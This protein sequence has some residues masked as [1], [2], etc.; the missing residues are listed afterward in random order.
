VLS[1]YLPGEESLNETAVELS[2][3][4]PAPGDFSLTASAD[5]M[6]GDSFRIEREP[7]GASNDP[8]LTSEGDKSDEPRAAALARIAGFAGIGDR[9][10]V[11]L[12]VSGT[13]G[14]NNVAAGART[15]IYGADAKAKL[16]T[17][18][19]AYLLVQA[20]YL[21][22]ELDSAGWDSTSAAY[23]TEEIKSNGGYI[24][25]DYAFKIR[26]NAGA[27]YERYQ[28]PVTDGPWDQAFKVYAGFS[29]ME[30]TTAF[31][32]D[33]DHFAPGT[34]DGATESPEAVDTIT[35]RVVFS[36]GPHK[37]HQF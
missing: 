1:T 35:L 26:Y 34:P 30:E 10:G 7:G 24:Y 4:I 12:G 13:A 5:W 33:W 25:A 11:E 21:R 3:R 20:E 36:M 8:L 16:W 2:G 28:Q 19:N 9:S 15:I 31:R 23:T 22:R 29:L 32:I 17:S 37:A 14:T 18:E 27:A 6:Q